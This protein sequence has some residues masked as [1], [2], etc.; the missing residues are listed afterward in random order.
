MIAD[1]EMVG[2]PP[3]GRVIDLHV[4]IH[5]VERD[6]TH[7]H[8]PHRHVDGGIGKGHLHRSSCCSLA[9]QNPGDGRRVPIEDLVHA[10]LPAVGIDFLEDIAVRIHKAH[11]HQGNPQVAAFLEMVPGQKTQA[12][13]V[14]RQGPVQP[15]LQGEIGDGAGTRWR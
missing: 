14:K 12:P 8:L 1:I 7:H 5:Q 13:G 2:D 4:G 3:V 15:V 9:I 10:F 6:A 11:R